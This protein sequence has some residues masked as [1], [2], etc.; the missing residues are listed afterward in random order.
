MKECFTCV[1]TATTC[2]NIAIERYDHKYG[3]ELAED[4]GYEKVSCIKCGYNTG[5]CCDC[6]FEGSDVC[7]EGGLYNGDKVL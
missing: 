1:R 2:P 5:K 4:L 6:L 7:P 3:D